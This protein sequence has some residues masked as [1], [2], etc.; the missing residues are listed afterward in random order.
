MFAHDRV[1]RHSNNACVVERKERV[2]AV[3][4]LVGQSFGLSVGLLVGLTI[5]LS[6]GVVRAALHSKQGSGS[7]VSQ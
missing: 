5:G 6:V 4:R 2:S 3:G 1:S 7:D